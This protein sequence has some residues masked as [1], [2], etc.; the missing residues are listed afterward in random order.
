MNRILPKER[1]EVNLPGL[2]EHVKNTAGDGWARLSMRPR[3][4]AELLLSAHE[5]GYLDIEEAFADRFVHVEIWVSKWEV[6]PYGIYIE[7][8]DYDEDDEEVE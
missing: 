7:P 6:A 1:H 5:M 4:F 2:I 3:T 8:F